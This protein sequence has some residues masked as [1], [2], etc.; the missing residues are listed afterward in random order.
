M[1]EESAEGPGPSR[2]LKAADPEGEAWAM[3]G[4]EAGEWKGESWGGQVPMCPQ[5]SRGAGGGALSLCV[6]RVT[7]YIHACGYMCHSVTAFRVAVTYSRDQA[8]TYK[9]GQPGGAWATW[10]GGVLECGCSECSARD[11]SYDKRTILTLCEISLFLTL[12]TPFKTF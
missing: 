11:T 10:R 2:R 4:R 3:Q 1:G 9:S 7:V 5:G 6:V 12:A 8:G